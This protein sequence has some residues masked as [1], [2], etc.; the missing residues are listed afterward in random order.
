[1]RFLHEIVPSVIRFKMDCVF[2]SLGKYHWKHLFFWVILVGFSHPLHM[3]SIQH[4]WFFWLAFDS[5]AAGS[6]QLDLTYVEIGSQSDPVQK[7][8]APRGE[9]VPTMIGSCPHLKLFYMWYDSMSS[10]TDCE[11]IVPQ[12]MFFEC[13]IFWQYLSFQYLA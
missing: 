5:I 8:P 12:A 3:V 9:R 13:D 6:E 2:F 4:E 10:Q 1:M 11:R 7:N